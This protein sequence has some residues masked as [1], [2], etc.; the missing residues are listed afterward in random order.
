MIRVTAVMLTSLVLAAC[1]PP[2]VAKLLKPVKEIEQIKAVEPV[3]RNLNPQQLSRGAALFKTNCADCHGEQGQGTVNWQK[4]GKD[5][6]FPPPPLNGLGHT[7]HHPTAVL[8]YTINN[9]TG[10]IGGNMPAFAN[11]LSDAQIDDILIF[12]QEKWPEPIYEAWYRTDERARN[13]T[14]K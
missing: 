10:K 14:P 12:I 3:K 4:R 7:W 9:G 1:D 6:K 5:G 13:S 11:K 8:K 2:D